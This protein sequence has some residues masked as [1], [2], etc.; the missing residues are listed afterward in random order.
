MT[1][2]SPSPGPGVLRSPGLSDM[3]A[4]IIKY[5]KGVIVS[6]HGCT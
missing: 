1:E 2:G 4:T 5:L 6:F 3:F